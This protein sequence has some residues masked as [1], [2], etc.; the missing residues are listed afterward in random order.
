MLSLLL[1][2]TLSTG[3]LIFLYTK[4]DRTQL[5]NI[6]VQTDVF[7]LSLALILFLIGQIF[8]ALRYQI[9]VYAA[10]GSVSFL[11]SLRVHFI[12]LFFN[13]I[14][15]SG[16]GGDAMKGYFMSGKI[17]L[18]KV[19]KSV[20]ADRIYGLFI[21]CAMVLILS[22]AYIAVLPDRGLFLSVIGIGFFGV[23]GFPLAY[24]WFVA[25]QRIWPK[26]YERADHFLRL[27]DIRGFIEYFLRTFIS[28]HCIPLLILSL[29]IHFAGIA[30]FFVIARALG[31][32]I[33]FFDFTLMVPL[34]FLLALAPVSIAGWGVREVS[35]VWLLGLVGVIAEQ[36]VLISIIFGFLL[37]MISL[38]G[39]LLF[40]ISRRD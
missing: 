34:V 33:S 37:I 25:F 4:L 28:W 26:L 3:I 27:N 5:E 16:L 35:S 19:V 32:D 31:V 18:A 6:F 24:L 12:G 39:L 14:M 15:L 38:P 22:M 29:M 40:V 8:S 36:A 20:I 17:S 30:T 1:K 21:L 7:M 23:F 9:L 10:G 11:F 13:Q 2:V